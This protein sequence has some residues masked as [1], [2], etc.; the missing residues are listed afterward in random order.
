[1]TND[2]V[3]YED[4]ITGEV[5]EGTR[6]VIYNTQSAA[7]EGWMAQRNIPGHVLLYMERGELCTMAEGP[8]G[9]S[10]YPA[11]SLEAIEDRFGKSEL[12][13]HTT[14]EFKSML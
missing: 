10:V 4:A 14:S 6:F 2:L 12:V 7:Q 11:V 5:L 1:M 9:Q 8:R 13:I 3:P